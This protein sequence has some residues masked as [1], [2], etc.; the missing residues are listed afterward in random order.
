M[1]GRQEAIAGERRIRRTV[2]Y[3]LASGGKV[4]RTIIISGREDMAVL[5]TLY[6]RAEGFGEQMIGAKG[7]TC[8]V[9][10]DVMVLTAQ[11]P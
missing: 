9:G 10:S 3:T 7:G 2:T 6:K 4:R 11:R 1:R 5:N 8:G